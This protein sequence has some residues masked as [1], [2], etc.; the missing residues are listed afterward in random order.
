MND[1]DL[2]APVDERTWRAFHDI[3]REVLFEARGLFGVYDEQHPDDRAEGHYPR[4][5]FFRGSPVAAVRI[6]ID[7]T[8]A[9]LRRVAVRTDAQRCGHG[10]IL[11]KM[12]EDFARIQGCQIL[13]SHVALDAVGFYEKCGFALDATESQSVVMSRP[14]A[15]SAHS[16]R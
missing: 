10:R 8:T 13:M 6:D 5:L 2:I 1:Y 11:L 16:D 3:R 12:V 7:G 15:L 4:A 14:V 9:T